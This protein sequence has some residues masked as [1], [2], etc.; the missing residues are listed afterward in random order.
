MEYHIGMWDQ[1]YY[2]MKS[3]E[4]INRVNDEKGASKLIYLELIKNEL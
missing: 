3:E 2:F 4:S 1:T